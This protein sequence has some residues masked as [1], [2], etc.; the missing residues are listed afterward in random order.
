MDT[1]D[2]VYAQQLASA[3]NELIAFVATKGVHL[4][5]FRAANGMGPTEFLEARNTKRWEAFGAATGMLLS[6]FAVGTGWE[7]EAICAARADWEA[8]NP[9]D[10]EAK[11]HLITEGEHRELNALEFKVIGLHSV[12]AKGSIPFTIYRRHG[13]TATGIKT[14]ESEVGGGWGLLLTTGW[15][16][17]F[18]CLLEA[19]K[20]I[21]GSEQADAS[22]V[23]EE[24]ST[25]SRVTRNAADHELLDKMMPRK[26]RACVTELQVCQ[27]LIHGPDDAV[28]IMGRG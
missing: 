5:A 13:Y 7:W 6:P 28:W 10:E 8:N 16:H 22:D 14:F 24:Q 9:E 12:V 19:A 15:S 26:K 25:M 2:L 3:T 1:M 17:Q 11:P 18:D 20:A 21:A 27:L 23:P 4:E